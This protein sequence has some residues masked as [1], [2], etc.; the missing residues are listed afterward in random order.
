MKYWHDRLVVSM[1]SRSNRK[2]QVSLQ[3]SQQLFLYRRED[4][5]YIAKVSLIRC[6][7]G[8]V[9]GASLLLFRLAHQRMTPTPLIRAKISPPIFLTTSSKPF[10]SLLAMA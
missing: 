4:T 1:I 10:G 6:H 3:S 9:K 5:S 8:K 7:R 2:L